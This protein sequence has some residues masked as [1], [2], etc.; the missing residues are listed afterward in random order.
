MI[1]DYGFG[2]MTATTLQSLMHQFSE[3]ITG[4]AFVQAI[5]EIIWG[6]PNANIFLN[7]SNLICRS[8]DISKYF[9]ESLGIRD[10]ESRL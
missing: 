4:I 5:S 1:L 8:T 7:S 2:T 10:K 9:R 3:M 6:I